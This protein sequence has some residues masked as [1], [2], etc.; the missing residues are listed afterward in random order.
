MKIVRR[1]P[2]SLYNPNFWP[3]IMSDEWFEEHKDLSMY[4]TDN[5]L[6]IKA[7]VAG[8][9]SDNVDISVDGG[10]VTI[11]AEH[12]ETEEEKK[13]KKVVYHEARKAQYL[14]SAT[15]PCPVKTDKATADITDGVL[16]LTL[17]KAEE[18]KPKK[19]KISAKAK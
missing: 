4:E 2:L 15:I 6:V 14:Y 17:P 1:D 7:N 3:S 16:I 5:D 12:E 11:K 19:I 9:P 10:V 8:V 13:S 18:A